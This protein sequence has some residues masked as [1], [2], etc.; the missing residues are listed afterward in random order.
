VRDEKRLYNIGKKF[1]GKRSTGGLGIDGS[2]ILKSMVVRMWNGLNWPRTGSV[3]SSSE[4]A[5]RFFGF[6]K[7]RVTVT[8]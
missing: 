7:M 1:E 2:I 4:H 5:N 3:A 6:Q 8:S